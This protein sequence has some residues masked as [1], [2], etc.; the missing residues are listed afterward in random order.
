MPE[1]TTYQA[2]LQRPN[3]PRPTHLSEL[4]DRLPELAA[5]HAAY[6]EREKVLHPEVAEALRE[7]GF[8]RHFVPAKWGGHE[9][10]FEDYLT[11]VTEVSRRDPSAG[12]CAAILASLSR[13]AAFL[14]EE[15]RDTVWAQ[16]PDA[17]VVGAL[18]P[19]GAARMASGGWILSGRW[20]YVSGVHF[21]DFALLAAQVP[22][23]S[24]RSQVRFLLVPRAA[25]GIERTWDT[26]GMRGTGSD[27]VVLDEVFVPEGHTFLQRQLATGRDPG[28]AGPACLEVPHKNVSGLTFAAP[29]LG[30]VRGALD[31]WTRT[32]A[33]KR[34]AAPSTQPPSVSAELDLAHSSAQTD[35]AELLLARA[36]RDA[37]R[38]LLGTELTGARAQRD[39]VAAVDL[40][41]DAVGRLQRTGGTGGQSLGAELQRFWRDANTAAG[42]AVL[43]WE[44][45][46][47]RF[48]S[49]RL[50]VPL[51]DLS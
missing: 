29:V 18:V 50:A 15:G 4:P 13:M 46:A 45:A 25:Y 20:P 2:P 9:G 39:H 16:G 41:L 17:L 35:A 44:P 30:A 26:V 11:A 32:T 28:G 10:G 37:D 8:A 1:T 12:W 51:G 48:G 33:H 24:G 7:A 40:L 23:P 31:A 27:T 19:G 6:A 36:A 5:R 3:G 47:R 43:K 22:L 34:A 49:A 14:P 21:S 38:G 42:H